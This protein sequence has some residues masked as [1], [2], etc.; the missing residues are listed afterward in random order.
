VTQFLT[1]EVFNNMSRKT[2]DDELTGYTSDEIQDAIEFK[3]LHSAT[4][5]FRNPDVLRRAQEEEG[6]AGWI[7]LEKLDDNRLRFKRP[8]SA[9]ANDR[10]VNFDA[11]RS[12]YGTSAAIRIIL[13]WVL[14]IV[15][16]VLLFI[17]LLRP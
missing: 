10:F 2:S 5:A 4:G 13:F 8:V 6:K 3:I 7:L 16:A 9:R 17:I 12:N 15:G 14:M 1:D 11:Y